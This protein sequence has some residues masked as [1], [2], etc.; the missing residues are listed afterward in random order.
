MQGHSFQ[1]RALTQA[2]SGPK[3]WSVETLLL[4]AGRNLVG[5]LRAL[6]PSLCL[7]GQLVFLL[8][9]QQS[10]SRQLRPTS[11]LA[12]LQRNTC[13]IGRVPW[14]GGLGGPGGEG[15]AGVMGAHEGPTHGLM[16]V[17]LQLYVLV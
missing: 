15:A 12:I 1:H 2:G 5:L 14:A 13:P 10:S 9:L 4:R 17:R 16:R 6:E 7:G 11:F 3:L 8:S